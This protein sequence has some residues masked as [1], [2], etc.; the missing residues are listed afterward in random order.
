MNCQWIVNV[1][2]KCFMFMEKNMYIID[3]DK[4][5]INYKIVLK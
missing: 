2:L 3:I 5:T 4:D 1:G